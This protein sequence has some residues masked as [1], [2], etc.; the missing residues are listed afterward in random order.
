MLPRRGPESQPSA[1]IYPDRRRDEFR[2]RGRGRYVPDRRAYQKHLQ[3]RDRNGSRRRAFQNDDLSRR[4]GKLRFGQARYEIRL[5]NRELF[6][7]VRKFRIQGF[8]RRA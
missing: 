4:D 6:G 3:K 2:R 8:R 7:L 5:K 1:G